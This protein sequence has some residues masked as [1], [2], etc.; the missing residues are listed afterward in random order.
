MNIEEE[1]AKQQLQMH[2]RRALEDMTLALRWF[3]EDTLAGNG[4]AKWSFRERFDHIASRIMED[5]MQYNGPRENDFQGYVRVPDVSLEP[6][7]HQDAGIGVRIPDLLV[8]PM[9]EDHVSNPDVIEEVFYDSDKVDLMSSSSDEEEDGD[10]A[11]AESDSDSLPS[12]DEEH[13]VRHRMLLPED[14]Y[15]FLAP[16]SQEPESYHSPEYEDNMLQ[17]LLP[18]DASDKPYHTRS[19]TKKRETFDPCAPDAEDDV[20]DLDELLDEDGGPSFSGEDE[21]ACTI[22][23]AELRRNNFSMYHAILSSQWARRRFFDEIN[24]CR[25]NLGYDGKNK[26]CKQLWDNLAQD[27]LA[28]NQEHY[29]L[30]IE[31]RKIRGRVPKDAKCEL[32]NYQRT[33]SHQVWVRG[34]GHYLGSK[35]AALAAALIS[36]FEVMRACALDEERSAADSLFLLD[37]EKNNIIQANANKVVHKKR[38]V[39]E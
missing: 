39:D 20:I 1:R 3:E 38:K 25:A 11:G 31:R 36:F 14:E 30:I 28:D 8:E 27:V 16:S 21:D 4:E 6:V 15:D 19:S 29:P 32:C 35:C 18:E 13:P 24:A 37:M 9:S 7:A 22:F 33:I 17:R 26:E 10:F 2:F 23:L 5:T 34:Y 12:D